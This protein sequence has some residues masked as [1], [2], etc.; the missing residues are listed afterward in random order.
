MSNKKKIMITVLLTIVFFAVLYA[1]CK[2]I[3]KNRSGKQPEL[4]SINE[5][6]KESGFYIAISPGNDYS[7]EE[8][9]VVHVYYK[10]KVINCFE[11][12]VNNNG[13]TLS[14]DFFKVEYHENY[15]K[16]M[17]LDDNKKITGVF[18]SYINN[19]NDSYKE[20]EYR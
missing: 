1:T 5:D 18:R 19:K 15:V 10:R 20:G 2:I 13:K 12:Y 17:I 14:E 3:P 7:Y 8:S 4:I 16:L 6:D 11:T 9:I